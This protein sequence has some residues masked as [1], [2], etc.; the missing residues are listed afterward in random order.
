MD[1]IHILYQYPKTFG[2]YLGYLNIQTDQTDAQRGRWTRTTSDVHVS[3]NWKRYS[4]LLI[5]ASGSFVFQHQLLEASVQMLCTYLCPPEPNQAQPSP[6]QRCG[7]RSS[8]IILNPTLAADTQGPPLS[9]LEL[10]ESHAF[11]GRL[12]GSLRIISLL[13]HMIKTQA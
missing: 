7:K 9:A 4:S 10:Q 11:P 12:P 3:E 8:V 13:R 2:G 5:E 1:I 6:A